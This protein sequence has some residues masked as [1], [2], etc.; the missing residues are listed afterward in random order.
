MDKYGN[1]NKI[2]PRLNFSYSNSKNNVYKVIDNFNIEKSFNHSNKQYK[3][4]WNYFKKRYKWFSI[5]YS[6]Q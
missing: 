2:N 1:L 3:H 6:K 4:K 5:Q